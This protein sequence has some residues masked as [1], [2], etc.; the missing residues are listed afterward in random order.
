MPDTLFA[1][2][3]TTTE[4]VVADM[5]T[6]D[7]GGDLM[8][9]EALEPFRQE[10]P[11]EVWFHARRDPWDGTMYA[12]VETRASLYHWMVRRLEYSET[13]TREFHS[14]AGSG[15]RERLRWYQCVEHYPAWMRRR[16]AQ[17]TGPNGH[18]GVTEV[19]VGRN[20]FGGESELVSLYMEIDGQPTVIARLAHTRSGSV[21]WT[22]PR[23]FT[24]RWPISARYVMPYS[25]T[26]GC[27]AGHS[28]HRDSGST[29]MPDVTVPR[30][31]SG[32]LLDFRISRDA[33]DR[34]TGRVLYI[35]DNG[36][37]HCPVAGC[38]LPLSVDM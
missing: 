8:P 22:R 5:L 11:A 28:W 14:W 31:F 25:A 21:R 19:R 36:V 15:Q 23:V 18:A 2:H 30:G 3:S 13:L 32:Y 12:Q 37:G 7:F 9:D 16:G 38:G 20:L 29:W 10:K 26:L 33:D 35:A 34:G 24:V 27:E 6:R 17:V 1:P 4:R